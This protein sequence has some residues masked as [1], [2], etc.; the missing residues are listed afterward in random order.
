MNLYIKKLI[1]VLEF[2]YS[3][4]L[5]CDT[6]AYE[7]GTHS[8]LSAAAYTQSVLDNPDLLKT[9]GISAADVFDKKRADPT[10]PKL[11]DGTARGWIR[12]GAVAEDDNIRPLFHFFDPLNDEGLFF[13]TSPVWTLEDEGN[14]HLLQNY[15][16]SDARDYLYK[17]LTLSNN[18]DRKHYFGKTFESLGRVIHHIQDMAQPQHV[19]L[20]AHLNLGW[21]DEE[22][23]FENRSRYEIYTDGHRRDALFIQY[24]S[25]GVYPQVSFSKAR[26]FWHTESENP[27]DGQG[28]AEFT[29]HNFVSAGTNFDTDRYPSPV[30][31]DTTGHNEDANALLQSAGIS[32]P[33][34][35]LPPNQPCAMTFYSTQVTDN[36]RPE[37]SAI[38]PKA[39]T[40]SIFDQ[41]LKARNLSPVFA[42]NRFNFD[43]AHK[44]LIPRAVAYSAG[45]INYFFR[46]KMEISLPDEGVYG[47]VDHSTFFAPDSPGTNAR[48]DFKGFDKIR[49]KLRNITPDNEPMNGG[50]LVAVVK[51]HR[52]L[53]YTDN[54]TASYPPLADG[55]TCRSKPEEIVVSDAHDNVALTGTAQPFQFTFP[56]AVPINATDVRLQVVYRGALGAENDAVAVATKDIAEP[57]FFTYMNASDYIHIDGSVYTRDEVNQSQ[58]LL[59]QVD[60]QYCVNYKLSP[61]QL[62]PGCLLPF[63]ITMTFTVGNTPTTVAVN[64]LP[65]KRF[66]R[67]AFLA[68]TPDETILSQSSPCPPT[69]PIHIIPVEWQETFD[70]AANETVLTYPTFQKLRGV[71]GWH[72]MSCVTNGDGSPPGAED[73]RDTIMPP[74]ED[75]TPYAITITG[76]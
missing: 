46:G 57:I 24:L 69:D 42:L 53:C 72:N 7:V 73:D 65:A 43:A 44:F 5:S 62:V 48:T 50:R 60:P 25:S 54:L 29:N 18:E 49:L 22:L 34:Q 76:F 71:Q 6:Q 9:L 63:P 13:F 47:I 41:D 33:S 45:L 75:E 8:E 23:P 26:D 38:N 14:I 21:S 36:Y 4:C 40:Q 2:F 66:M 64:D 58:T 1:I 17:A 31:T 56:K 35:C 3:I 55:D 67:I 52:N 12:E 61:P 19:R 11:N 28:L 30:L 16:F 39:A 10:P 15:S 59:A 20:D 68:D 32:I 37:A 51:F 74:L 27:K 70:A